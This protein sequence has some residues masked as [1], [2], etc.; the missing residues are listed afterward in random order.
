MVSISLNFHK[1]FQAHGADELLKRVYGSILVNLEW[2]YNVFLPNNLENLPASKG[3]IVYW[4]VSWN[5]IVF[6]SVLEKFLNSNKKAR[7]EGTGKLSIIGMMRP[8]MVSVK[9]KESQ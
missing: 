1:E 9:R 5:E 6:V 2:G 3:S 8:C 4:L 7:K